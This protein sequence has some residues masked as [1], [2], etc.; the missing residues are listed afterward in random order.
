MESSANYLEKL[1]KEMNKP[2]AEVLTAALRTGL[3]QLWREHVLGK[4]LLK[5]ISRKAA[6]DEV[7][8]DWVIMAEHHHDAM[9]ED[10][11]WALKL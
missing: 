6:I 1:T 10:I 8:I 3:R 2:E 4:Y 7:G 5:K 11:Q 9:I